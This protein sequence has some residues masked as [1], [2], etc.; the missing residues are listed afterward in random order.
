MMMVDHSKC[1]NG[2]VLYD[3]ARGTIICLDTAEVLDDIIDSGPEWRA[4]TYDEYM[5]RAR[6]SEI[7]APGEEPPPTQIHRPSKFVDIREKLIVARLSRIAKRTQNYRR[8]NGDV[9][10]L[11]N[12]YAAKLSVPRYIVDEAFKLYRKLRKMNVLRGS[13]RSSVVAAACLYT[14][15]RLHKFPRTIKEFTT[16]LGVSK[17]DISSWY[18]RI[19]NEVGV[20]AAYDVEQYIKRICNVLNMRS[21]AVEKALEIYQAVRKTNVGSGKNP[22]G[23]AAAIVYLAGV[24]SDDRRTMKEIASVASVTEVTMR[25]RIREILDTLNMKI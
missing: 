16:T 18:R 24:L 13:V 25:K 20:R 2:N 8:S 7:F 12:V 23:M 21:T 14:A 1:P 6:G 11:I 17:R 10:R 22:A 5:A 15:C 4:Y 3:Y 9:E 19:V